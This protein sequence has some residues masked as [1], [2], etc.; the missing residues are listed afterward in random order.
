MANKKK[1]NAFAGLLFGPA[2]IGF[3]ILGLWKNEHR[4]DYHKAASKTEVAQDVRGIPEGTVFSYSG[5]MD[6]GLTMKG[7]Y[8]NAFTGYL[9]VRRNAEIYAWDRD[10]DSDGDV[11]W[12]RRWMSSVER[13]SR[14]EGLRQK[15]NSDRFLP[16]RFRI[17]ELDVDTARVQFVDSF[18]SIP[19]ETLQ[20]NQAGSRFGFTT[21]DEYYYLSKGKADE[22]GDERVSF[23]GL[24][25]PPL[26]SYFGKFGGEMAIA[27]Q[28]VTRE[29]MVSSMI[30]DTGILHHVVAGNREIALATMKA[31]IKRL[32]MIV[33]FVGTA[34]NTFGWLILFGTFTRFLIHIPIIGNLLQRGVLLLGILFG[35]VVSILTITAAFVTSKPLILL[36]IAIAAVVPI[37]LLRRNAKR[38]QLRT[39]AQLEGEL[40]HSLSADEIK[41]QEFTELVGIAHADGSM[42]FTEKSYLTNWGRNHGWN[43][44]KTDQLI[45]SARNQT[46]GADKHVYRL[47]QL[48][49]ADG[50]IDERELRTLRKAAKD[51]G[52]SQADLQPMI[53]RARRGDGVPA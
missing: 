39:R 41:E 3:S 29:G 51:A 17:G 11:T 20:L 40:G 45:A 2:L 30:A 18:Q 21:R 6:Q 16:E 49:L 38:S 46:G 15:L 37:A 25:V 22:L 12:S 36:L 4:F 19:V 53:A 13:N 27:H 35:T 48:M 52:F 43:E 5:E 9:T 34:V 33:R 44:T 23:K 42:D 8:V 31:H 28:A 26:A 7:G 24:P 14:N 1:N 50:E 47:I 32:K 10:E